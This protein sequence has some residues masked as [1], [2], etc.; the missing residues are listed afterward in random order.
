MTASASVL[1][2]RS[3]R[4]KTIPVARVTSAMT[5]ISIF[6]MVGRRH[7]AASCSGSASKGRKGLTKEPQLARAGRGRLEI[8]IERFQREVV[9]R[10]RKLTAAREVH[11]AITAGQDV[12]DREVTPA[13]RRA[14]PARRS[15][16]ADTPSRAARAECR[17]PCADRRRTVGAVPFR[18]IGRPDEFVAGPARRSVRTRH[19]APGRSGFAGK[20]TFHPL[21][22]IS[23]AARRR[24]Q[25][26]QQPIVAGEQRRYAV[27]VMS[28]RVEAARQPVAVAVQV[29][30]AVAA[31][32]QQARAGRCLGD[33]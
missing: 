13:P 23:T 6:T 4:V 7:H 31:V 24:P 22:Q 25:S 21:F 18:P 33:A 30:P 19:R 27:A 1:L 2:R 10:M 28:C 14:R 8:E 5:R 17:G 15:R 3:V 32:R 26:G 11:H 9:G 20:A 16:S 29:E 12:L